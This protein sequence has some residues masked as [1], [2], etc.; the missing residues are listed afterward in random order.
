M[1]SPAICFFAKMKVE[2]VDEFI[3]A[4]PRN[5]QVIVRRLRALIKECLPKATEKTN[6]GVPY[7][8]HHRLICFIWPPSFYWGTAPKKDKAVAK[9]V[10]LG[11]NY[12]YLMSNDHGV[13]LAE[14]RKQVYVMYFQNIS[15]IDDAVVRSQLYEAGLLDD[16][17]GEQKNRRRK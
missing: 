14:G 11:F 15:E 4:L 1:L 10:S 2:S 9:G 16:S 6:Y 7:Y 5:E 13:L 8:A 3:A 17:F 12:G